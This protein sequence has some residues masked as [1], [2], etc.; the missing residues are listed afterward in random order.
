MNLAKLYP[1]ALLLAGGMLL[2]IGDIFT[3]QWVK[4]NLP[5]IFMSVLAIYLLGLVFLVYSFRHK[6]IA[7][8]SMILVLFNIITLALVSSKYYHEQ[9]SSRELVGI[10]LGLLAV[11]LLEI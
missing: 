6:N 11:I 1:L 9:L 4:T 2:T 7:T 5:W 3:K 10:I 8:A